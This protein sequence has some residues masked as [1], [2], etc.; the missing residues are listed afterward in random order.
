MYVPEALDLWRAEQVT[1]GLAE[2]TVYNQGLHI[3][4]LERVCV[5]LARERGKRSPLQVGEIDSRVISAYFATCVGQQGNRNNMLIVLRK[6]LKWAELARELPAGETDRLLAAYR[7]RK[8]P[9]QP[10]YY[11]PV[12]DFGTLIESAS[13]HPCDRAVMALALYTLCRRSE[14]DRL[15]LKDVDLAGQ[16]LHVYRPKRRRWTE[17]GI[18]PELMTELVSWLEWLATELHYGSIQHLMEQ[19]PEWLLIPRLEPVFQ[20]NARGQVCGISKYEIDPMSP[21]RHMERIVKRGLDATGARTP[22][23]STVRHVGEGL[24]TIRRS[25]ARAMLDHLALTLGNDK[26][27]LQVATMLDHENPQMTLVYIGLDL[28]RDQLNKWLRGHSMYGTSAPV[29]HLRSVV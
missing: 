2:N 1:S 20:R 23:G 7:H 5:Q 25:G 24:H 19:Q 3:S 17:V 9:R 22:E 26:A 6:F 8:A 12:E 27:L 18:S 15:R 21:Q 16:T 14:I 13:R 11:V 10:K 29:R 4:R 28:E